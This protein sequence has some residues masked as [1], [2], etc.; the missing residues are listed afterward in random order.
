MRRGE[1][2]KRC[3]YS[4]SPPRPSPIF[5]RPVRDLSMSEQSNDGQSRGNGPLSP[6]YVP[7]SPCPLPSIP[8]RHHL[9][10]VKRPPGARA[11]G[12]GP[13]RSCYPP[14]ERPS[15]T[16]FIQFGAK[17]AAV[18][19]PP[20]CRPEATDQRFCVVT[21]GPSV[22]AYSIRRHDAPGN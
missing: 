5:L 12:E 3:R 13:R 8:I 21:T 6:R 20:Q 16:S 11:E 7:V 4:P 17:V 15:P 1:G 22:A 19:S 18:D 14:G 9:R 2:P 10:S